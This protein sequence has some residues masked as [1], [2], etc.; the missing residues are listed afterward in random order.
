ME[1]TGRQ[2]R[3]LRS[4]ANRLEATIGVGKAGITDAVVRQTDS[5]LEANE[6]V[7]CSVQGTSGMDT[8]EAAIALARPTHAEVVQVIGHKFVLYRTSQREDIEHIQLV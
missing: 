5:A 7:K 6:L 4:M 3:Q 8:H 2:I 1:L